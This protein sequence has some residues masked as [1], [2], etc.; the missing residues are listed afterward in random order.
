MRVATEIPPQARASRSVTGVVA[1]CL[2]GQLYVLTRGE[3]FQ[4]PAVNYV[5]SVRVYLSARVKRW[6]LAVRGDEI[7][8]QVLQP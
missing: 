3:D 5:N 1:R 6:R 4:S 7:Y 8:L 2:D